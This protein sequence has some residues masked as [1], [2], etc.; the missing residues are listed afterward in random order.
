[1]ERWIRHVGLSIF[2]GGVMLVALIGLCSATS[3]HAAGR[4]FTPSPTGFLSTWGATEP[5][6]ILFTST[7]TIRWDLTPYHAAITLP[8]DL[9]SS[10]SFRPSVVLTFTP[11]S[12]YV[13]SAPLTSLEHFFELDGD[14]LIGGGE[15][16]PA[17]LEAQDVAFNPQALPQIEWQ[18]QD[19]ELVGVQETSIRLYVYWKLFGLESWN[20]QSGTVYPESN[21]AVFQMNRVGVY[22][23]GGYRGLVYLPI[24]LKNKQ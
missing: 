22:G 13:F 14:Y 11:K 2:L 8:K 18:Y 5:V 17:E 24:V 16:L 10:G 15:A 12:G 6:T 4:P 19:A 20:V 3:L 7:Q 9:V 21:R 1:M 23:F